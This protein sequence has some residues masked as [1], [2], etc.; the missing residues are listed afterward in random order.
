M[1]NEQNGFGVQSGMA[2]QP[3]L[4]A[5]PAPQPITAQPVMQPDNSMQFGDNF[6]NNDP[7]QN[8]TPGDKPKKKWL[9]P[10]IIGVVTLAVGAIVAAILVMTLNDSSKK[11]SCEFGTMGSFAISYDDEKI[12]KVEYFGG[13]DEGGA[14]TVEDVN[15]MIDLLGVSPEEYLKQ[16]GQSVGAL[17]MGTCTLN[18]EEITGSG[19]LFGN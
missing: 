16:I 3:Q 18:G 12:T 15:E 6:A 5:Q 13:Y 4:M 1:E 14:Q 10:T 7:V 11:L 19:N 17:G 2:S 9:L 8:P